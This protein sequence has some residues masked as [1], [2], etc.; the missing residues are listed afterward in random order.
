M[1]IIV[2]LKEVPDMNK[3]RFNREKGVVDRSSA[4]AEINPFDL[5]ALQAAVDLKKLYGN[6]EITALSMGPARALRSLQDAYARGADKAVL[7]SDR[8]FGGSDTFATSATL[9]AGIQA[10]GDFDLILC[11]EKSVDGDTAQVGAEVAEFLDIAHA[12]HVQSIHGLCGS[13]VTVKTDK[14]SGLSQKR[15]LQLPALLSVTK[16]INTPELPTVR[17]K[18]DSLDIEVSQLACAD[19]S[20]FLDEAHTGFKGS[21]TKVSRI[22]IPEEAARTSVIFR[23]NGTDFIRAATEE[24]RRLNILGRSYE[25]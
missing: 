19:L 7:L 18:L 8:K 25:K 12:Y 11:G 4:D 16:N 22:E 17:R 2:L 9:A 24:L 3:V 6:I 5:N 23:G 10:L 13:A 21:P 14:L 15:S 20:E 1:K